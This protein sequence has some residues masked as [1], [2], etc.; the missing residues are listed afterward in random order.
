ME[1][2][3]ASSYPLANGGYSRLKDKI[4]SLKDEWENDYY[5]SIAEDNL[6]TTFEVLLLCKKAIDLKRVV[7]CLNFEV[8]QELAR[9][10]DS[11]EMT[12]RVESLGKYEHKDI[13]GLQAHLNLLIHSELRE[14][15]RINENTFTLT[16]AIEENA[17]VYFALPALRF[18][19]CLGN[20]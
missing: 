20:W 11:E 15:F 17:V 14:Y 2:N 9:E 12:N 8:L 1:T 3:I 13:I 18:P 6:Q 7:Q 4:I 16:R 10:T 5:R 19:R